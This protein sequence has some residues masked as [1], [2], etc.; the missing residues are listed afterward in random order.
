MSLATLI[1]GVQG[2][3][4]GVASIPDGQVHDADEWTRSRS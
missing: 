1:S 2:V 4:A 3:V